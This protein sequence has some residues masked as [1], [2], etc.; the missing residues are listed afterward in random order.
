MKNCGTC[1]NCITKANGN[2]FCGITKARILNA[3]IDFNCSDYKNV[4][5]ETDNSETLE[6][7]SDV[8]DR[9]V[10]IYEEQ[11]RLMDEITKAFAVLS[12]HKEALEMPK[13]EVKPVEETPRTIT[14]EELLSLF[15]Q[16][17]AI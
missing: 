6:V 10:E 17:G 13:E 2:C 1:E 4:K 8:M 12:K 3:G 15:A 14:L 9:L 5:E 16:G 11:S 7:I